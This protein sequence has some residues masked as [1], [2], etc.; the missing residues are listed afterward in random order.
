MFVKFYDCLPLFA[1]PICLQVFTY[2]F[3]VYFLFFLNV[4]WDCK[5]MTIKPPCNKLSYFITSIFIVNPP[6]FQ[7]AAK[8]WTNLVIDYHK[9]LGWF[10]SKLPNNF[11]LFSVNMFGNFLKNLK[12]KLGIY[13]K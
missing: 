10:G 3:N 5:G 4:F 12:W 9:Y 13:I 6:T 1:P 8:F 2:L 11:I 7:P